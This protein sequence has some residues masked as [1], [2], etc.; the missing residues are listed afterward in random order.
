MKKMQNKKVKNIFSFVFI[1]SFICFL[2]MINGFENSKK[3]VKTNNYKNTE[4][5]KENK[6]GLFLSSFHADIS[7]D[8]PTLS[9]IY[10]KAVEQNNDDFLGKQLILKSITED[11]KDVISFALKEYQK[12]NN[13]IIPVMY[14]ANNYFLKG[15][16]KKAYNIYSNMGTKSDTF[17][18]KLLKSWVLI[19]EKKYDDALDL[20]E[21][22]LDN[23]AFRKYIL[24][25]LAAQ[26]EIA[27]DDEYADELYTEALENEKLNIFDIENI[28]AFYFRYADKDKVIK[29]LKD[30]YEKTPDSISALSLLSKVKKDL[31]KPVS[32]DTA[33]KGMAKALFDIS[34]LLSSVFTTAQDL[35]L[36]YI[37]MIHDLYPDFYMVNI[38]QSEIYKQYF[39]T[40][41]FYK[42]NS[43]VPEDHYLYL[44]S[45]INK[46]FYDLTVLKKEKKSLESFNKLIKKYPT[47][48]H[49]YIK[50]ADYYVVRKDYENAIKYYSK[51]LDITEN[52]KLKS[53]L[54]FSRAQV[55]DTLNEIEK[56]RVDL[57]ESSKLNKKP[58]FLN[59]YGYFLISN[60]LDLDKGMLFVANAVTKE[61]TNPYYLDSYGWALFKNGEYKRALTAI[62]FAKSLQ[63]KNPVIIDHLGDIYWSLN[64]KR[65]AIYEW[66]KILSLKNPTTQEPININKIEYKINYGL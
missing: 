10:S 56:A 27:K 38:V 66:N 28:S 39:L 45:Q 64:R 19:A 8:L 63:P 65:E 44:I 12:N 43:L 23:P 37:S 24:I 3:Y 62:Q 18:I 49:L 32:I 34:F 30:Y 7:G 29:I 14:L 40:E 42:Y 46:I 41:N 13:N 22:E 2:L 36:M 11:K 55:Y 35:H 59:Y 6:Y 48:T 47:Y 5:F 60:N 58:A 51:A 17:I 20:L 25:H 53:N 21:T 15:D 16:Y 50:L 26:A 52:K 31:Y 57:E 33:Q 4:D 1:V 9:S 61:P 54:Y